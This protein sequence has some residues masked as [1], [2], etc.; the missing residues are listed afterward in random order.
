MLRNKLSCFLFIL[1]FFSPSVFGQINDYM[2]KK[3]YIGLTPGLT[4]PTGRV[5]STNK[6]GG[7]LDLV[8]GVPLSKN[9]ALTV[10]YSGFSMSGKKVD[11]IKSPDLSASYI[12]AGISYRLNK[13]LNIEDQPNWFSFYANFGAIWDKNNLIKTDASV[14]DTGI[15]WVRPI[16]SKIVGFTKIGLGVTLIQQGEEAYYFPKLSGGLGFGFFNK[17]RK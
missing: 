15:D 9:F 3:I 1:L 12:S 14:G 17:K 7:N 4:I 11:N 8:V 2:D 10:Q 13:L 6:L 16:K 5:S